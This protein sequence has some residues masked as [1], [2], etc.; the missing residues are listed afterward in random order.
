MPTAATAPDHVTLAT[1]TSAIPLIG[2]ID[3]PQDLAEACRRVDALHA[4]AKAI[5]DEE[6]LRNI[7]RHCTVDRRADGGPL[8]TSTW[9]RW[10]ATGT[11][12]H[13]IDT[14]HTLG[15]AIQW[16]QLRGLAIAHPQLPYCVRL[17]G[18]ALTWPWITTP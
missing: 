4:M 13:D 11:P 5:A 18:R 12:A 7:H 16:L 8:P 10:V 6:S 14:Q 2:D 15:R 3:T 1:P 9:L 17:T